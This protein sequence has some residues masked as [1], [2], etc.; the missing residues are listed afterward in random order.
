[1]EEVMTCECGHQAFT[2]YNNRVECA[3]CKHA[4][5]I[6]VMFKAAV[7]VTQFNQDRAHLSMGSPI[8]KPLDITLERG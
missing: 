1:M 6:P 3:K 7:N 8:K 2:V 4:Y 5:V